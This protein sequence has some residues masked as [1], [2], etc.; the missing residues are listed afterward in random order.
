V[1]VVHKVTVGGVTAAL[2]SV[3]LHEGGN[4]V[5]RFLISSDTEYLGMPEP[6]VSVRDEAGHRYET[7][8]DRASSSGN[9]VKVSMHALGLPEPAELEVE[10]TR[11]TEFDHRH[12]GVEVASWE[13]PWTFRFS[14]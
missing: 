6:E 12:G 1:P 14:I 9:E 3:E 5:L 4:G 10:I 7:L 2:A 8:P 11:L 13:G